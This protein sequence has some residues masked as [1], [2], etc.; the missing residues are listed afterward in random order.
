[1]FHVYV[2]ITSNNYLYI[3]A[4]GLAQERD[5]RVVLNVMFLLCMLICLIRVSKW[6]SISTFYNLYF[7]K[8]ISH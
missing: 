7:E 6:E 4:G 1:M 8:R 5:M 2:L 3:N